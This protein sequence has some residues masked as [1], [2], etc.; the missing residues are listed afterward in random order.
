MDI[1]QI[2]SW[3]EKHEM[4]RESDQDGDQ[5]TIFVNYENDFT[6]GSILNGP[7]EIR[8]LLHSHFTVMVYF[9]GAFITVFECNATEEKCHE[10]YE[11]FNDK[12]IKTMSERQIGLNKRAQEIFEKCLAS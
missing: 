8:I 5:Y 11:R 1:E 4:K 7:A 10:I 12:I 6:V 2:V 3:F 9:L